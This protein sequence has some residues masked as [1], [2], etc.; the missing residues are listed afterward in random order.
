MKKA[1]KVWLIVASSLIVFGLLIFTGVMIMLK[2]DFSKLSNT[3]YVTNEYEITD[4]F[5][6]VS[7][8]TSTS[9]IV[10][11]P[12]GDGKTKVVCYENEKE[13]LFYVQ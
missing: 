9:D 6:S 8:N 11:A 2:W 13:N 1:T 10:F 4:Q 3:K 5:N 7:V 12:S